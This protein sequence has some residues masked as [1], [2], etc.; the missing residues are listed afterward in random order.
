MQQSRNPLKSEQ[1][2]GYV[3]TNSENKTAKTSTSTSTIKN[4]KSE[5]FGRGNR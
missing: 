5:M 3:Y 2:R 4:R 1:L